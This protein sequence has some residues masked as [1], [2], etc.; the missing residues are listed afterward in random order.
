MLIRIPVILSKYISRHFLQNFFV[1]V[2]LIIS[3]VLL[4]DLIELLRRAQNKDVPL[5]I[6]FQLVILRAP[7]YIQIFLPFI[8]LLGAILSL[9]KLV[10]SSEFVVSRAAGV[11][12]WQFLAPSLSLAFAIGIIVITVINPL[13]ATMLTK[14]EKLEGKYFRGNSSMLSVSSS[15]L[16][17]RQENEN[18][19]KIIHS[20]RIS[21]QDMQLFGVT[22][23]VFDKNN[24]FAKR[25]DSESA[26]L[27]DGYWYIPDAIL[28]TPGSAART[29][30]NYK[31]ATN[32]SEEDIKESF[33][34]PG[35]I[36]FWE[37][38]GFISTL[39][40]AG[41]SALKHVLHWHGML[42][43]PFLLVGMVLIAAIFS[44]H[45]PRQG[46]VGIMI[47]IGIFTGITVR[48][49]TNIINALGLSGKIPVELAAW[50]PILLIVFLSVALIIHVEDS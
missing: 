22:I 7:E 45:S 31:L 2:A 3:I 28:T 4:F 16:W 8:V 17:L 6:I 29:E 33:A 9:S 1:V 20:L 21:N 32:L 18:G 39:K 35:T 12:V 13:S 38:P 24:S 27:E 46:K 43:L 5:S 40:E 44:L 26:K 11:S 49:F 37:L 36:S 15:G 41:F 25:I 10:R 30:N 42:A 19:K 47:T 23:Y 14:F 50:A 48:F 34:S